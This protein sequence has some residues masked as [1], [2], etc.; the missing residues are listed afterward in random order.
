MLRI[1]CSDCPLFLFVIPFCVVFR[2]NLSVW[3]E[4]VEL[5]N[6]LKLVTQEGIGN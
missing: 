3:G 5:R 4:D 1:K 6:Q 2:H